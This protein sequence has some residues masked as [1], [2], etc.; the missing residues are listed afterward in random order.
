[1]FSRLGIQQRNEDEYHVVQKP[2]NVF[3]TSNHFIYPA[4]PPMPVT[5]PVFY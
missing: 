2:G 5:W 3:F 1:M 4:K